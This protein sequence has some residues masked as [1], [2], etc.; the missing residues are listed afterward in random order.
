[1]KRGTDRDLVENHRLTDQQLSAKCCS[2]RS[3]YG[4]QKTGLNLSRSLAGYGPDSGLLIHCFGDLHALHV[5]DWRTL[6]RGA[7]REVHGSPP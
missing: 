5:F 2:N 3:G 1:M 6:S 7:D 4:E